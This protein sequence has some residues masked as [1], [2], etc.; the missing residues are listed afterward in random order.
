MKP[1]TWQDSKGNQWNCKINLSDC[2]R[3]K[4]SNGFDLMNPKDF[5]KMLQDTMKQIETIAEL[6]RPQWEMQGM[7]YLQFIDILIEEEGRFEQVQSAFAAAI[8]NFSQSIG[9]KAIA[10]LVRKTMGTIKALEE[11]ALN[12]VESKEVE[13]KLQQLIEKAD[14]QLAED[15]SKLGS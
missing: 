4:E 5:E 14:Q 9:K 6:L 15:L 8:E 3:L 11:K 12:R 2:I 13:E 1:T 10:V 7:S